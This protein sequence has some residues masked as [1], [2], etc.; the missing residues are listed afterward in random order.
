MHILSSE[1]TQVK[2][3]LSDNISNTPYSCHGILIVHG[4][5]RSSGALAKRL[6]RDLSDYWHGTLVMRQHATAKSKFEID[7][8]A[9]YSGADGDHITYSFAFANGKPLIPAEFKKAKAWL[10]SCLKKGEQAELHIHNFK[11]GELKPWLFQTLATKTE[12]GH[13]FDYLLRSPRLGE[14]NIPGSPDGNLVIDAPRVP[15]PPPRQSLVLP[16]HLDGL[17]CSGVPEHGRDAVQISGR[18]M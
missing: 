3:V 17:V 4:T 16:D 12:M 13:Q 14:W 11:K 10:K 2:T 1:I 18:Q 9:C 15:V 7:F 6:I 8:F 5:K